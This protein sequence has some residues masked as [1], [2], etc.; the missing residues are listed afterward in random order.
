MRCVPYTAEPVVGSSHLVQIVQC[1]TTCSINITFLSIL[2]EALSLPTISVECTRRIVITISL[3]LRIHVIRR[4]VRH[5]LVTFQNI[6]IVCFLEVLLGHVEL[7]EDNVLHLSPC[8]LLLLTAVHPHL[9]EVNSNL[10]VLGSILGNTQLHITVTDNLAI[11]GLQ[12]HTN[13]RLTANG[14]ESSLF[15]NHGFTFSVN[16]TYREVTVL[17]VA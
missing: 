3:R 7:T 8:H 2:I 17:F 13:Q 1:V 16:R 12:Q 10:H 9:T 4:N 14:L 15:V 11:F 5:I 6:Q